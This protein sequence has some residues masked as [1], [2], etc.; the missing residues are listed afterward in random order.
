[1]EYNDKQMTMSVDDLRKDLVDRRIA[2]RVPTDRSS[3][4]NNLRALARR[5][6]HY[7]FG[8]DIHDE[9]DEA[10]LLGLM[11]QRVGISDD[12]NFDEGQDIIDP[13]L[14]VS[15]LE[16][17]AQTIRD[18]VSRGE[19]FLFA[20]GHPSCLAWIYAPI[21]RAV[22][23][24]GC[25]VIS[26]GSITGSDNPVTG[27]TLTVDAPEPGE[28]RQVEGVMMRYRNGNLMHTHEPNFMEE[29]IGR[30]DAT[31]THPGLV[32]ADH[33]WAGASGRRGYRTVGIADCNDPALFVAE[34]Q[35]EVEVCVPMDD[36]MPPS[37]LQGIV[38]FVL[39]RSGLTDPA[40]A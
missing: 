1:M 19:T 37:Q 18:S 5:D 39:C 32:V 3:N 23:V 40:G 38:S 29:V 13:D 26:L 8:V 17:Y 31:G 11:H 33:G 22:R 24:Q 16:R 25:P 21:A 2:G 30:L 7:M 20:T 14:T 35:G 10:A 9:W 27:T 28:V 6:S 34:A 4:I 36:G 12:P 15:A